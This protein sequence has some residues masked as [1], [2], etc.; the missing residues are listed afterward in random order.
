MTPLS[1]AQFLCGG[2]METGAA[3]SKLFPG[4]PG[5]SGEDTEVLQESPWR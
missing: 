1:T 3:V 2:V 4:D 5:K